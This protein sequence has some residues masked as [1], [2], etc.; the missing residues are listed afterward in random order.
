MIGSLRGRIIELHPSHLLLEVGGVGYH[1]RTTPGVIS[2]LETNAECFLYIHEN[3]REDTHDL[4]GFLKADG[5]DLFRSLLDV[6]GV[7][8]KVALVLLS[9]GKAS[10]VRNAILTGDIAYLTSAPGVGKKMAQKIILEL[11]GQ[12][13]EDANEYAG[14]KDVRDALVG[15]GYTP[16]QANEA[17]KRI[18]AGVEDASDKIREALRHLSK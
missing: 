3:I 15:L 11:K 2:E 5:L 9:L 4:F 18:P 6:S 10:S 1:V 16:A 8:P 7:G 13:V 17:M 12:L 14:D